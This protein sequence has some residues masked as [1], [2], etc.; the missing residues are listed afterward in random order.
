MNEQS[1]DDLMKVADKYAEVH[2]VDDLTAVRRILVNIIETDE[3]LGPLV[4]ASMDVRVAIELFV[5]LGIAGG[6]RAAAKE[7]T[8]AL[9]DRDEIDPQ[10][11]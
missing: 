5:T 9:E 7:M 10:K 6:H 3:Y 1:I 11:N 4:E 2:E 8:K